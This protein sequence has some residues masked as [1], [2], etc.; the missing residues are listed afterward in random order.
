MK[1]DKKIVGYAVN[2]QDAK[3]NEGATTPA[4][5]T[6]ADVI[7]MHETLERPDK[8]IGS[9]YKL[10]VPEHVS[11]HAMYITINDIVLNEG[12]EHEL[13]RPFEVFINSKNLDHFQ[14]IVALTRI[15]SAV[16]RKGGDVTFLV[17]ELRS[18]FDPRG[19]YWNKGKYM[20][21]IIAEIGEI[22]ERHLIDIGMLKAPE[23]D[24]HQKALIEEKKAE[25]AGEIPP[26][27]ASTVE[28]P[29]AEEAWM[30]NATHCAKCNQKAVVLRDGCQTCLNC[31]DSKCG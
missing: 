20:P 6:K 12:T 1:I 7:Q 27:A 30:A 24:A 23:L 18:V 2:A 8:L 5:A 29:A 22:I 16:F 17:E 21:S 26:V 28:E 13:R 11:G 25:L 31:G 3:E 19:G 15:M 9:T 4:V 14:W 10:K